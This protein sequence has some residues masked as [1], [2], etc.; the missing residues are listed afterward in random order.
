MHARDFPDYDTPLQPGARVAVIGAGNTAMDAMRVCLRLGAA[1]VYCVYRR[2]R[3]EAPARAEELHHAEDEGIEFHWLTSPVEVLGDAEDNVRGIR[4]QRM[5]LGE[6]D[7]S[8]RRR[9]VP[10]PDSEFEI[11]VDMVVYAIGTNANPILG[12]TSSLRLDKRGYIVTGPGLATSIAG[13]WAGG[14]IVTGAATV[15][16]AMGAGRRAAREI[17][18]YLGLRD[19][20]VVYLTEPAGGAGKRFGI[21][22]R[23]HN[24]A[25]VT[26]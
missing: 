16:E 14:D 5:E 6:P 8:G 12:Q 15:I 24:Y 3:N 25:R 20:D 7:E 26:A 22:L 2:T 19:T 17:K 10:V 1:P 11:D 13:V 21:D 9:P 4:C 23:E 18:A